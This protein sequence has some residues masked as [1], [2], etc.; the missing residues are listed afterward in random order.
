MLCLILSQ[1]SPC[2]YVSAV[3]VFRKHHGQR[4]N[5]SQWAISPFPSVFSTLVEN[6]L[7]FSSNLKSSTAN[8]FSFEE[9]K[10]C[11]LGK[12]KRMENIVKMTICYCVVS[13]SIGGKQKNDFYVPEWSYYVILQVVRPSVC[14]AVRPWICRQ[15]LVCA[16]PLETLVWFWNYFTRM[17]LGWPFSNMVLK[18]LICQ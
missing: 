1:T 17:V 4:R 9:S 10:I 16:T 11:C 15:F 12:V 2:F 5:C 8:P 13:T 14:L 18:I 3:Q 7:R 6:F